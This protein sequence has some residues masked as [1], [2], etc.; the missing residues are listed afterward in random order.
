MLMF[1]FLR[2]CEEAAMAPL[3]DLAR[4]R[5]GAERRA[6]LDDLRRDAPTVTAMIERQLA[7]EAEA[8]AM[9]HEPAATSVFD[10]VRTT[11]PRAVRQDTLLGVA[12]PHVASA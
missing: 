12:L 3:L 8:T 1:R 2:Q 10:T 9:P 4:Q 11:G 7:R 6:F 5:V